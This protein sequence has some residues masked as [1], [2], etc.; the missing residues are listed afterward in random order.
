MLQESPDRNFDMLVIGA[1]LSGICA[2]YHLQTRCPGK[3]YAILEGRS[4][5]G[6]T[7]DLFRYPG[8]RSDSDMFTMGFSFRSWRDAKAI[9]ELQ[10]R[11]GAEQAMLAND[12]LKLAALAQTASAEAAARSLSVRE[13]V[14]A[15]HGSFAARFQPT[16]PAP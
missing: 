4:D 6:G 9:A 16:P 15:N 2:G 11:I 12:G 7:W 8:I 13:Q 3:S 5:I 1:G 10:G 14:V